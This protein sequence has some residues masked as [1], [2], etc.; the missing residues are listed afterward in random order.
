MARESFEDA[1]VAALL[2][3]RFVCIK[4][5]REERP[6]VDRL[7]QAAV[8]VISGP[9]GWPLSAFLTPEGKP[10]HG[11]SY[12]PRTDFSELARKIGEDWSK[13]E[14]RA[15]IESQAERVMQA[16]GTTTVRPPTSGSATPALVRNAA[17][18]YLELLDHVNGGFGERP[19]FPPAMRLSVLL[20]AQ[21][22]QPDSK[23][24]SALNLTLDRMA[25]GGIY[26]QIGG[27]FHRYSVDARWKI[28]HFEKMLYDQALLAWVYLEAY[29]TTRNDEHRRI[30][31]ETLD[32]ALRELRDPRGGFRSTLN[33]E[34][35]GPD[36]KLGEGAF[37]LWVPG[38]IKALLGEEEGSFLCRVYDISAPGNFEG[39]SL[40]NSLEQ[41]LSLIAKS[42]KTTEPAL[43]RRL[44]GLRARLLAARRKRTGPTIDDKVLAD[45]N[46]LIIRALA[47]AYDVTGEERYRKAAVE[48][49]DFILKEMVVDGRLRHSWRQGKAGTVGFL[50]DYGA[51]AVG[52][53][54]LHRATGEA[55]WV[56]EAR[57]LVSRMIADYYDEAS[58]AF[59]N[60]PAG[61]VDLVRR[62]SDPGDADLPSGPSLATLALVML[63]RQAKDAAI[64]A[65]AGKLLD[66]YATPMRRS[67]FTLANSV[68]AASLYFAGEDGSDDTAPVSVRITGGPSKLEAGKP[69]TLTVRLTLGN[70]WHIN[71]SKPDNAMLIPTSIETAD[72]AVKVE[73]VTFPEPVSLPLGPKGEKVKVHT[74][75]FEVKVRL[76]VSREAAGLSEL[77]LAVRYQA[78]SDRFCDRPRRVELRHPLGAPK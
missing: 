26:D 22:E 17:K 68:W 18:N 67:P 70:G 63:G 62:T 6:D 71:G 34:S 45:W 33:A 21:R 24:L 66:G 38:E 13:P 58:G 40:P 64:T 39:K 74:G 23:V 15:A 49:A 31:R 12:M 72:E 60:T 4:V 55:R 16:L 2:N 59:Y 9:A 20:A 27:G 7:Y 37:Y 69:V 5:D 53:L 11:G 3:E 42:E 76:A 44:A 54:S 52:L 51:M 73:S 48:T 25:R 56:A 8:E 50:E 75:T 65:R 32:F 14:G 41:S 1:G 10:F 78:C 77:R 28:P 36:G 35:P 19:K 46:G 43:R 30:G 61:A 29:R 47:T 57:S